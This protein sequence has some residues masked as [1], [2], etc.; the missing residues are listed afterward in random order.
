MPTATFYLLS[1]PDPADDTERPGL[2]PEQQARENK[3][4]DTQTRDTQIIV[5]TAIELAFYYY[6]QGQRIYLAAH[7]QAQAH[8][9][10]DL[11]WQRDPDVFLPHNLV[12]EGPRGGAPVEIGWPGVRHTGHRSVLINLATEPSNF[13]PSFAQVVDFVPCDETLKQH[14]RHRYKAY[15][16]AGLQLHTLAID[17]SPKP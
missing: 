11:L 2:T 8:Q 3:D 16:L 17:Q 5:A 6:Q 1:P 4:S 13:A 10:D 7:D 14:A 15:R 12:G 9:L